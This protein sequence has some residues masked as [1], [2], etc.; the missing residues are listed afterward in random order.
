MSE[1]VIDLPTV[2]ILYASSLIAGMFGILNV[3]RRNPNTAGLGFIALAF[4]LLSVG[5]ALA[6]VG[7][8]HLLPWPVFW[9]YVN[10]MLGTSGYALLWVGLSELSGG[11]WGRYRT[12]AG[13]VP[14][15]W[16]VLGLLSGFIVHNEQRAAVFHFNAFCFLVAAAFCIWRDRRAE[17]LY[18]RSLLSLILLL[19]GGA[20][21][22]ECYWIVVASWGAQGIARAFFVQIICNFTLVL[23]VLAIVTERAEARLKQAIELDELTGVGNRRFLLNRLPAQALPGCAILMVDLDHFKHINDTFGHL[24]GDKV[25]AATARTLQSGLRSQDVIARFGGEEFAIFLP[26]AGAREV[27]EIA[28]RLRC[29]VAAQR[30]DIAD[31]T[32]MVTVSLGLAWIDVPGKSWDEWIHRADTACYLAK[33]RGRNGVAVSGDDASLPG[34]APGKG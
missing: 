7:E 34:S 2:L 18:S 5:G 31:A 27:L 11:P 16:L 15:F 20:Y 30:V 33:Q 3:W 24:A 29:A 12:V 21:G 14:P 19:S 6:G 22:G 13:W 1:L 26:R 32:C 23:L 25:L 8:Y 10:F 28:E 17:P 9:L 4:A